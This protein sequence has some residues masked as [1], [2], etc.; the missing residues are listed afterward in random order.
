MAPS[1]FHAKRPSD[2]GAMLFCCAAIIAVLIAMNNLDHAV[3]HLTTSFPKC[4][5]G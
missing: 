4:L 1:L 5:V 3:Q 2:D